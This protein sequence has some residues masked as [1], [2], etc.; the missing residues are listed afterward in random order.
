M[1]SRSIRAAL[2]LPLFGFLLYLL[3]GPLAATSSATVVVFAVLVASNGLYLIPRWG[4]RLM[5]AVALIAT[6]VALLAAFT[7]IAPSSLGALSGLQDELLALWLALPFLA[8]GA[9]TL[10]DVSAGD[11]LLTFEVVV[12]D[13]IVLIASLDSLASTGTPYTAA[14]VVGA[15]LGALSQQFHSW[16]T[17]FTASGSYTFPLQSVGGSALVALA[18]I[19]LLG[20]LLP[21]LDPAPEERASTSMPMSITASSG[22]PRLSPEM[23]RMLASAS[24]PT[25]RTFG[26]SSATAALVVS[27]LVTGLVLEVALTAPEWTLAVAGSLAIVLVVASWA[28][29]SGSGSWTLSSTPRALVGPSDP[30]AQPPP[31]RKEPLARLGV[32]RSD[33]QTV[34]G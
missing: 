8:I 6:L 13:S 25:S 16:L 4:A 17:L 7:W 11:L 22:G 10:S 3:L 34:N 32:D 14:N 18:A 27:A 26:R 33:E 15:S 20:V 5:S 21:I 31:A 28:W 23:E 29:T 2:I 9:L 1:T 12:L 24:Q 19:A 30:P